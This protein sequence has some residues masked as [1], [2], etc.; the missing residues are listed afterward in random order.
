MS[1]YSFLSSPSASEGTLAFEPLHEGQGYSQAVLETLGVNSVL[2]PEEVMKRYVD[3]SAQAEGL[4]EWAEVQGACIVAR[5]VSPETEPLSMPLLFEEVR[6]LNSILLDGHYITSPS[7]LPLE[8]RLYS[9]RLLISPATQELGVPGQTEH[10]WKVEHAFLQSA[11]H[12]IKMPGLSD[13]P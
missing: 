5:I 12:L 11:D 2:S 8:I 4:V 1:D 7:S 13:M 6:Y 3:G 10:C 9:R